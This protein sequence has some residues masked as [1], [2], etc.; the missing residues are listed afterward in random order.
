MNDDDDF[1][2]FNVVCSAG[3]P[4]GQW[5]AVDPE[6]YP[7]N[8]ETPIGEAE[9]PRAVRDWAARAI[10]QPGR[11]IVF[12]VGLRR[13]GGVEL[14]DERRLVSDVQE[15]MRRVLAAHGSPGTARA[16][17]RRPRSPRKHRSAPGS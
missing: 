17:R 13:G 4:P 1:S 2:M 12:V 5:C 3:H 11:D 16:P 6:G 15:E 14:V 10:V 9:V 7:P 8:D